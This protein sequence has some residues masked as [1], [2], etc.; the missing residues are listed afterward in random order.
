MPAGRADDQLYEAYE[1]ILAS[2]VGGVGL[3]KLSLMDHKD[4]CCIS[5][6]GGSERVLWAELSIAI[7]GWLMFGPGT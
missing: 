7:R 2:A 6:L 4:S 5:L 3:R 1:L